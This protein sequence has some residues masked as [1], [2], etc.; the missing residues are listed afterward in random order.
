MLPPSQDL[1]PSWLGISR[2]ITKSDA[3]YYHSAILIYIE[4][5]EARESAE[6]MIYTPHGVQADSFTAMISSRPS[7]ETLAFLRGFA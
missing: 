1:L 4:K 7:V 3:L 2:L 5:A 6:A